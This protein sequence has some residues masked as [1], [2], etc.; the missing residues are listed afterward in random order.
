MVMQPRALATRQKIIDAAVDVFADAG[1]LET[2]IKAI[3]RAADLTPG[4]FYYHFTSKEELVAVIIEQ[5]WSH[6]WDLVIDR[7]DATEPGLENV[8]GTTLAMTDLFIQSK[9]VWVASQLNQAFGHLHNDGRRE[10]HKR[11][12]MFVE[13]VAKNIPSSDIRDDVTQQEVGE[14]I[15]IMLQGSSQVPNTADHVADPIHNPMP[16]AVK[17]WIFL[18]RSVVPPASLPHFEE[19]LTRRAAEYHADGSP[20]ESGEL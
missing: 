5:G 7:L 9:L 8:I 16:R 17:N 2:D 19:V 12:D 20:D 13:K 18:L 10:L 1:Y 4:A 11:F 15:W 14:L 3:T 6:T